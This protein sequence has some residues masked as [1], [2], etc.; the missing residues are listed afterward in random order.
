MLDSNFSLIDMNSKTHEK[1]KQ[2]LDKNAV[3]SIIKYLVFK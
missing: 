2:V 1:H 3:K